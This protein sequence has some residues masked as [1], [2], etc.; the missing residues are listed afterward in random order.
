VR[1]QEKQ[2]E[3]DY[4]LAV[5]KRSFSGKIVKLRTFRA[6]LRLKTH[7]GGRYNKKGSY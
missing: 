5:E 3:I 7:F 2:K 4:F 1:S 6:S